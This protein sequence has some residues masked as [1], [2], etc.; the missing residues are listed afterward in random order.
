AFKQL[1]NNWLETLVFNIRMCIGDLGKGWFDINEKNF[2]IYETSKLN[3]F[4]E[5]VKYRMQYTLRLL[6]ENTLQV[7]ISLVETP[8]WPCLSV[9]D[10][11]VWGEDLLNSPFMGQA[12]PLFSLQL[13]MDESGA[14]YSTTPESFAEVLLKLFDEALTQTH[15]IRQVHPL[16]LSNL[17]FP[18]DLCL[19]SVGLLAEEVC[20][21]RN[22][23][24]LA[25][26]K[27]CIPLR[28]YAKEFDVHVNLYSLIISDYI[29][30]Y[31]IDSKTAAE[32][33]EDISLHHRL[34]RSL[35]ETLPNLIFIGPFYVQIDHLR[36]FLINKRQEII[37]KLLDLFSARMKQSIE[38]L[39]QEYKNVM[40]KL[41]VKP[42]SIEHIF[43]IRDWMETI[44]MSVKSLE[45][46]CKRYLLEYDVLDH[47]WYALG[48]EDFENKW[49]AIGWPLRI[50][51]QVDVAD[52][53]LKEEEERYYKLQLNDE[54]T[55]NDRIDTLTTQV[56][57]MSGYRD[58]SKTHEY[59][60]EIRKVW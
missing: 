58:V 37:N 23:F 54:F 60:Q 21:V 40:V 11:F 12:A 57:S 18:P 14:F 4:M 7:F 22:R 16:L 9:E 10:D 49:E 29:K 13:R 17:R 55:L 44:P 24:L 53:F 56:V 30:N 1:K 50:Y 6:V 43:E 39:L 26:E 19:S 27:A 42:E 47:F 46:T 28:A 45:E 59:T 31:E 48:N 34:K 41:A 33:K 32:V 15:Q 25:Y 20:N 35:E 51:Q 5:L 52:K 36:V 8:C 2:K 3:R 38:D